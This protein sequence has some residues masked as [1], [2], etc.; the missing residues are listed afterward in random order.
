MSRF[1]TSNQINTDV[2]SCLYQN[3]FDMGMSSKQKSPWM[4]YNSEDVADSQFCMEYLQ[5]KLGK[6][7]DSHLSSEQKAVARAFQKMVD[8]HLYW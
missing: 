2:A 1:K 3:Q 5:A 7:L 6:D 8:E 4:T